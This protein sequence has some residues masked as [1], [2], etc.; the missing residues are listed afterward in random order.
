MQTK[1]GPRLADEDGHFRRQASKFRSSIP[2]PD[3][4][5]E[6]QR[7]VL[8]VNY[9]CPWAHRANIVRTLKG[10]EDIIQLV[11]VDD[12]DRTAGKGWFFSGQFGGPDRDPV[13]GVK[14]ST[15]LHKPSW[16]PLFNSLP[17]CST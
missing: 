8:Y 7:Y 17:V 13:T 12:M 5:A 4:P 3:F 16:L 10:L 2:S 14:V 6:G 1:D 9:G 15:C 11:V